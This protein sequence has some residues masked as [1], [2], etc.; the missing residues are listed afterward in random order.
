MQRKIKF[1]KEHPLASHG[2]IT[3]GLSFH[4]WKHPETQVAYIVCQLFNSINNKTTRFFIPKESGYELINVL[5]N[6]IHETNEQLNFGSML[7][8][9]SQIV[10]NIILRSREKAKDSDRKYNFHEYGLSKNITS[11]LA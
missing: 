11:K 6:T 7:A 2:K 1:K 10:N 8:E 3:S 9:E 4:S 5:Q